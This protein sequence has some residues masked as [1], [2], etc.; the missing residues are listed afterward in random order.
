MQRLNVRVPNLI[1][2][3]TLQIILRNVSLQLPEGYQLIAGT[4]TDD[5]HLYFELT[6]VSVIANTRGIKLLINVPLKTANCQFFL[7]NII[8]LP[9]RVSQA[10]FV[11]FLTDF[12]YFGIDYSQRDY[13][14]LSETDL[15]NCVKG[16]VTICPAN[17]GVYNV[18]TMSCESSLFF[19]TPT[20]VLCRRQL[21]LI[22]R[23]PILRKHQTLWLYYFPEQ[24]QVTLRCWKNIWTTHTELLSA[25]GLIHNAST[26]FI[27]TEEI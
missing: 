27:S 7:Y 16:R 6:T 21:L 15:S 11:K 26:C 2:V 18:H 5:I 8:T 13:V 4:K 24:R 12:T 1:N 17:T 14:L 25:A 22:Y 3:L 19:Q 9:I 20:Y 23:T 10:K